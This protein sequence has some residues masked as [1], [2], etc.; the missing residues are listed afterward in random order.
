MA[1]LKLN[2]GKH[3]FDSAE[4]PMPQ[5]EGEVG[6]RRPEGPKGVFYLRYEELVHIQKNF[7]VFSTN[8]IQLLGMRT[9]ANKQLKQ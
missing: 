6:F 1:I 7:D 9:E 4:V 8:R 2:D 3:F 5:S